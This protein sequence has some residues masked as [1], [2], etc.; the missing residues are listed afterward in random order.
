MHVGGQHNTLR[1]PVRV[2]REHVWTDKPACGGGT[3][4]VCSLVFTVSQTM[5]ATA[6]LRIGHVVLGNVYV[7]DFV[8]VFY[9]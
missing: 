4:E 3:A 5:F 7:Y 6:Y 8:Y 2:S 9:Y 1:L